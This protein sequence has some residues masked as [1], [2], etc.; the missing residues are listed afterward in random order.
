MVL[1]LANP[2]ELRKNV[3]QCFFI[4]LAFFDA[5]GARHTFASKLA[6]TAASW[7]AVGAS[8]L[9]KV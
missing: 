6:P 5:K 2:K 8:L 7:I 9:A 4:I 3:W 1:F